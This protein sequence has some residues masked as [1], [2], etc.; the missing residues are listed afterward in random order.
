MA[1]NLTLN[2]GSGG[3][4]LATDDVGG[5]HY[6]RTKLVW[7]V[8]GVVTDASATNPLPVTL[9]STG[10]L[11]SLQLLD[12]TVGTAS[13]TSPTKGLAIVGID[14]SGNSQIALMDCSGRQVV[15]INSAPSLTI[16][17]ALPAG[18]NNIGDVDVL[19]IAAGTNLIGKVQLSDGTEHAVIDSNN[20]LETTSYQGS[21]WSVQDIP[22]TTGG[23]SISRVVAGS[24]T[25]ATV[26]KA[27]AGH[28]YGVEI[29]N[30]AAAVRFVKFHNTASSPTAG[31]GVVLTIALLAD[32]IRTIWFPQ[33]IAFSTGIGFTTVTGFADSDTAA[34]TANDLIVQVFY[35]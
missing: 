11:A 12:D 23:C 10:G 34:V 1:D 28:L 27:S 3:S 22:G 5:A 16:G 21:T 29:Y 32:S 19:S 13:S 26:A 15:N 6:Q 35:K 30:D 14:G 18:S 25:N 2:V 33:G 31:T 24:S 20:R 7:G 17:S 9:A 8:D 4:T